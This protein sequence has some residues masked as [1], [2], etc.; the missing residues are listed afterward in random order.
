MDGDRVFLQVYYISSEM[1][2]G[3]SP[4]INYDY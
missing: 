3:F 2:D 1:A 4:D